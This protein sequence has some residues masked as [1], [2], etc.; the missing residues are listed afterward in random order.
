[1]KTLEELL[2]I[3]SVTKKTMLV[4]EDI[5]DDKIKIVVGMG[6]CGIAAGARDVLNAFVDGVAEKE[7]TNVAVTQMGCIDM[8]KYE[9]IV[10]VTVPGKEKVTYVN[11]TAEKAAKVI[12]EH[13]AGGEPV[14]EYIK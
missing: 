11:M 14:S 7:L 13:I 8:C 3:Q 10:E 12:E 4:R 5:S 2:A 1:M 6:T 9:P